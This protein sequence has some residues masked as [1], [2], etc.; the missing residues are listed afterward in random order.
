MFKINKIKRIFNNQTSA[1]SCGPACI[2]MLLNYTGRP[3][4]AVRINKLDVSTG[5]LTLLQLRDLANSVDLRCR[6]VEMDIDFLKRQKTPVILHTRTD[7]GQSHFQVCFGFVKGCKSGSFLLADPAIQVHYLNEKRLD[8]AWQSK[9]AIFFEDINCKL[10]NQHPYLDLLRLK[11]YPTG[12]LFIIPM[13]SIGIGSF[14]IA[15]TW[16]LQKGL[17]NPAVFNGHLIYKVLCLLFIISIFR[18]LFSY[19]RQFIVVQI[20]MSTNEMLMNRL[21]LKMS[22][23]QF[24]ETALREEIRTGMINLQ[25]IQNAI[26]TFISVFLSDGCLVVILVAS[27]IYILP[28]TGLTNLIYLSIVALTEI[29]TLPGIIYKAGKAKTLSKHSE[30]ALICHFLDGVQTPADSNYKSFYNRNLLFAK[31]LAISLSK[32]YL[33]LEC[34][35]TANLLLV[36]TLSVL[37]FEAQQIP[38]ESMV[39]V[40]VEA[41]LIITLVQR[42]NASF[43]QIAEGADAVLAQN[44][45]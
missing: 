17:T 8:E 32:K 13:L 9:A 20:N 24:H 22:R 15:F 30:D 44:R 19:L 43:Q 2:A 33:F 14:S 36:M 29:S 39:L 27:S 1:D 45:E 41:Y 35:G 23:F 7:S 3:A 16:L 26:S 18:S 10:K 4:D 6:C 28:L 21:I 11:A 38:F 31:D 37:R 34:M 40:M 12:L 42:I 25:K 5:G